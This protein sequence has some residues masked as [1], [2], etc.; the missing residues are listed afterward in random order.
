MLDSANGMSPLG[1]FPFGRET[2]HRRIVALAQKVENLQARPPPNSLKNIGCAI[3]I[4][5]FCFRW[6]LLTRG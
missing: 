5:R 1:R 6:F 3:G 2:V 4:D